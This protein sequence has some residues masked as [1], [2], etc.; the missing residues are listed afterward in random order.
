MGISNDALALAAFEIGDGSHSLNG[1]RRGSQ[2]MNE[3]GLHNAAS[4]SSNQN[5]INELDVGPHVR[6]R[7]ASTLGHTVLLEERH[8][9]L[10]G[11]LKC[12]SAAQCPWTHSRCH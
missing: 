8:A 9:Y 11:G 7:S 4:N 6:Q 12:G 10:P 1:M 5:H 2:G 3:R